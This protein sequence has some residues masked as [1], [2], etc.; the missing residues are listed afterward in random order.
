VPIYV[1][2]LLCLQGSLAEGSYHHYATFDSA[3]FC[4]FEFTFEFY[5]KNFISSEVPIRCQKFRSIGTSYTV[6]KIPT[7]LIV[8]KKISNFSDTPIQ[9]PSP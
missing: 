4:N 7:D 1:L 6:S 2:K 8:A 9:P 3:R 5:K